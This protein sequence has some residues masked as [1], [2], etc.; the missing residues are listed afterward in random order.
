M[1][2]QT[3]NC[4]RRVPAD[5]ASL[6]QLAQSLAEQAAIPVSQAR[7]QVLAIA[8]SVRLGELFNK[9]SGDRL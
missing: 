1:R 7:K 3:K 9:Q 6:E 8:V 2:Y 4:F 5:A